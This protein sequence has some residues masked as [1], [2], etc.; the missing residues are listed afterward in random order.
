MLHRSSIST[1]LRPGQTRGWFWAHE[2]SAAKRAGAVDTFDC[3]KWI[4]YMACS[5]LPPLRA[6]EK[7][8]RK[9]LAVGKNTPGGK[10][11]KLVYNSVYG[12]CCQ[13]AGNPKFANAIYASL[14]TAGCRTMMLDAIA[15]HPNGIRDLVMCATDG[16]YFTTPHPNLNLDP[17]GLGMW[18]QAIKTNLTLLMPGVYWDDTTRQALARNLEVKL[19]SRGIA[20]RDLSLAVPRFDDQWESWT[21]GEAHPST[22]PH[23]SIP[24]AFSL[25]SAKSAAHRGKWELAGTVDRN[26]RRLLS[27]FPGAKRHVTGLTHVEGRW[28]SRCRRP[29]DG[30]IELSTGHKRPLELATLPYQK[31]FG[32]VAESEYVTPGGSDADMIREA[33]LE[34]NI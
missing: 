13:S 19:K 12:K 14:I 30:W 5:C 26:A 34:G 16:I 3:E 2:L 25:L 21:P 20:A 23:L 18:D 22:W 9:R 27:A 24:L 7:L 10:A 15:T 11:L 17:E 33:I 29:E 4:S 31:S 6:V 1:I 8:Y 32:M 28:E